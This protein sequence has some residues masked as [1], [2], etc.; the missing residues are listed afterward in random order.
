M[1]YFCAT[2]GAV[3]F[4][5]FLCAWQSVAAEKY[6]DRPIRM[7]VPFAPGGIS[8]VLA[9]LIAE[10]MTVELGQTVIVDN[11]AGASGNL[12]LIHI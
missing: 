4:L 12:S 6:P 2:R 3:F 9:R 5:A 10:K 11:R 1:N 7:V 8:D